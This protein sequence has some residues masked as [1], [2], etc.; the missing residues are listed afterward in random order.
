[1]FSD[2]PM[3]AEY[4]RL[5]F[6]GQLRYAQGPLAPFDMGLRN[7]NHVTHGLLLPE[8]S[9]YCDI[10]PGSIYV[11][12]PWEIALGQAGEPAAPILPAPMLED[13]KSSCR[14]LDTA[15]LRQSKL[16]SWWRT[17]PG[18]HPSV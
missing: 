9:S 5:G 2:G 14:R 8:A 13:S 4:Y 12:S 18:L 3:D 16:S 17:A 15:A 10:T 1:M 6:P 7:V 11:E